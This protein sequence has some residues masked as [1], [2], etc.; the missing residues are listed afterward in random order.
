MIGNKSVVSKWKENC[1]LSQPI[2]C[3]FWQHFVS[4]CWGNQQIVNHFIMN[5]PGVVIVCKLLR[6]QITFQCKCLQIWILQNIIDKSGNIYESG[7]ISSSVNLVLNDFLPLWFPLRFVWY[8]S[9]TSI[10]VHN[11]SLTFE[12]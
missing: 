10:A 5:V 8:N 1:R 4:R 6:I 2:N 11:I 3:L 7:K 12:N 9:H